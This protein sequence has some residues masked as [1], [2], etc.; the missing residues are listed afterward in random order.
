[1][2]GDQEELFSLARHP[3]AGDQTAWARI[4]VGHDFYTSWWGSLRGDVFATYG[5]VMDDWS[6]VDDAWETG[7]AIS[8]PGQFLNGKVLL[9]YNDGGELVVGFAIGIPRWWSVPL[10]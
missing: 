5:V 3:L 1:M 10:P 4:G 7:V 8:V 9:V 2:L 6:R